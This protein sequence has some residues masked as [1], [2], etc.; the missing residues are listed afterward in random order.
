ML[1]VIRLTQFIIRRTRHIT[2]FGNASVKMLSCCPGWPVPN[3]MP[4]AQGTPFPGLEKLVPRWGGGTR[5]WGSLRKKAP[6]AKRAHKMYEKTISVKRAHFIKY[7]VPLGPSQ[8]IKFMGPGGRS[9]RFLQPWPY[10]PF[11]FPLLPRPAAADAARAA[12]CCPR[13][14][15]GLELGRIF[16]QSAPEAQLTD[17]CPLRFVSASSCH[18][19]R[20]QYCEEEGTEVLCLLTVLWC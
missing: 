15:A 18:T 14:R 20:G 7:R 19:S 11:P 9:P 17:R 6:N 13:R 4:I 5:P 3:A 2:I 12:P 1:N 8:E 10:A 16:H